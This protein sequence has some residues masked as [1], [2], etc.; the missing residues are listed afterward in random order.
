[1]S[2]KALENRDSLRVDSIM[3][4]EIQCIS[5]AMTVREVINIFGI[6]S[7]SSAPIIDNWGKVVGLIDETD[8]L[9]LAVSPGLDK[10]ISFCITKLLTAEKLFTI[11]RNALFFEAYN[12]FLANPIDLLMVVDSNT[13][14]LGTVTQSSILGILCAP[15]TQDPGGT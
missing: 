4:S 11:K 14:L 12:I 10:H 9:K 6:Q 8:L 13:K 3:T 7:L 2:E 1:M 5:P 15:G